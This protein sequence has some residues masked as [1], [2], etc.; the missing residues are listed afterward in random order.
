MLTIKINF[1]P[2]KLNHR[3]FSYSNLT[4]IL[5]IKPK[6]DWFEFLISIFNLH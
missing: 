4:S 2:V 6:N 1:K 3:F 5:I